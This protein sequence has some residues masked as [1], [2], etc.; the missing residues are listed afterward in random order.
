MDKDENDDGKKKA[1]DETLHICSRQVEMIKINDDKL[2]VF[3]PILT[4]T[5]T[6]IKKK[7]FFNIRTYILKNKKPK[8]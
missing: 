8:I 1:F 3:F 5:H 2:S 7:F 6:H 4:H